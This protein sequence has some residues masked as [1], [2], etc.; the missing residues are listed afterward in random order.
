MQKKLAYLLMVCVSPKYI[1]VELLIYFNEHDIQRKSLIRIE[2][3]L[4]LKEII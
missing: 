1:K 3:R 2:D 4:L